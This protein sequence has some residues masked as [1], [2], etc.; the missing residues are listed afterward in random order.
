MGVYSEN[1]A[2]INA[3][4][5]IS[6]SSLSGIAVAF[7]S[8][9]EHQFPPTTDRFLFELRLWPARGILGP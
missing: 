5:H 9:T 6:P 1:C 8:G 2:A 3:A 7:P 4:E